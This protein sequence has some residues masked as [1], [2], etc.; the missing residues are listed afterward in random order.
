MINTNKEASEAQS[1]TTTSMM[2]IPVE[3]ITPEGL[4]A[5]WLDAKYKRSQSQRTVQEYATIMNQFRL[6]IA[7]AGIDLLGQDEA[8]IM[9]LTLAAQSFASQSHRPGR[10]VAPATINLRLAALSSF[11]EYGKKLGL[12]RVN[13][14]ERC[15]RARV[16][17]YAGARALPPAFIAQKLAAIDQ[18]T[19]EGK[20]DYA[21]ISVFLAS[22]RRRA[23]V[24]H[25]TLQNLQEQPDQRI[26]L[27]FKRCKGG[28]QTDDLLPLA[29]SAALR[30]W[31]RAW[32]GEQCPLGNEED[33][34]PVW[35]SLSRQNYGA[36]LGLQSFHDICQR[37]LGTS[38]VHTT[39]HTFAS[40]MEAVGAPIS[41]IQAKLGHASLATTGRYMQ[42]LRRPEN[43]YGES[44]AT[45]LG[46][47]QPSPL[48][49]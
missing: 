37:R 3:G 30:T 34:R 31:L 19:L 20:R 17:V 23:E 35:V 2:L 7:R 38:K 18:E 46:L 24:A 15:E 13:P 27:N 39:R 48:G 44:L 25:L 40:T 21:L 49:R 5:A 10:Q 4:I 32:Y 43:P 22:G 1:N 29:V 16:T 26:L 8:S 12:L 41:L 11:Y 28:G 36:P 33:Q 42:A 9:A 45:T 47:S 6:T 14:I